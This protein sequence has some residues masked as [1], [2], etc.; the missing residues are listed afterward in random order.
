[1]LYGLMGSPFCAGVWMI[2]Y[3]IVDESGKH[4]QVVSNNTTSAVGLFT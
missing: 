1:V 3:F 4:R 2:N